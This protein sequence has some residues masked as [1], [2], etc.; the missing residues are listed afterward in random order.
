MQRCKQICL[1]K[2]WYRCAAAMRLITPIPVR[3]YVD[4]VCGTVTTQHVQARGDH[5]HTLPR[6]ESES[7]VVFCMELVSSCYFSWPDAF[8][9]EC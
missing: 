1:F 8:G 4:D 6:M 7:Y 5:E 2:A 3:K 9:L